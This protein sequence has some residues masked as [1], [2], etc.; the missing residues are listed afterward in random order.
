MKA[1]NHYGM[2]FR[3]WPEKDSL[4]FKFQGP[5]QS[6]L[7]ETAEIVK[8]IVNK[9]GGTGFSLA[10]NEKEAEAI[11]TDRKNLYH[12]GISMLENAR[13]ILTDVWY[14]LSSSDIFVCT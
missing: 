11:W 13:A 7:K 3:K 5:T 4:Y 14:V 8:Q 10:R 6:S 9:H 2:S 1:T 12:S